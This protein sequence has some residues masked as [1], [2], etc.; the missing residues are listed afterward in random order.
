MLRDNLEGRV[1]WEMGRGLR[2]EGIH[3]YLWLIHVDVWR[4]P[5]Q[6]YKAMILQFKINKTKEQK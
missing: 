5:T 1:G 2:R 3:V 4:K 6:Y